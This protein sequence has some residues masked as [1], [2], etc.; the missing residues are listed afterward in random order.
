MLIGLA[1]WVWTKRSRRREGFGSGVWPMLAFAAAL[2]QDQWRSARALVLLLTG[3]VY[4]LR[5]EERWMTETFGDAWVGC[6]R[7]TRVLVPFLF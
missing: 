2:A 4:K 7:H 5:L 3:V 6:R 1:A